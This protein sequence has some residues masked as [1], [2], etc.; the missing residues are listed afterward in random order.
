M[1]TT[2]GV[3]TLVR[4]ISTLARLLM[5]E[6]DGIALDRVTMVIGKVYLARGLKYDNQEAGHPKAEC[7]VK[8]KYRM[9]YLAHDLR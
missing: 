8:G 4:L 9:K 1:R 5:S 2:L 7:L 6:L 3:L